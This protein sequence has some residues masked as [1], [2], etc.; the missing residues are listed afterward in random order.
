MRPEFSEL[1]ACIGELERFHH[2]VIDAVMATDIVDKDLKEER[3]A[4]WE[5]VFTESAHPLEGDA[6]QL[7]ASI[8]LD[9][10]MQAADVSH[11]MQHWH[12]YQKWNERLFQE[13]WK[14]YKAGHAETNPVDTWYKGEMGFFDFYVIPLAKK[15]SECGV[16]GVSSDE[17]LEYALENRREWE[18]EG[19][20]V[21]AMLVDK[22][23]RDVS[24]E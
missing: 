13:M 7:K 4:R 23:C 18:R 16:F 6:N 11:T 20:G 24:D 12:I 14:A 21:V 3:N 22:Y 15:L 2:L 19:Q 5:T 8:V 9:H 1:R 17:H 10:M